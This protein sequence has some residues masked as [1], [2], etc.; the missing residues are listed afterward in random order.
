MSGIIGL[1]LGDFGLFAAFVIIGPRR[2]VLIM[3]LSPI[4][5]AVCAYLML[6]EILSQL[7]IIGIIITLTGVILV[8]LE[9]EE[10]SGE[11]IIS[12]KL[13]TW[14]V[15]LALIGAIGQGTGV[16]F[17]KKGI[18]L[19][20]T[21]IINPLSAT[22]IRMI[23]GALFVWICVIVTRRLPEIRKAIKNKKGLKYTIL[24]A[25]VGPFLG[26]TFS[27]T[28]V[29]FTQVGIA[30]TLMSLMPVMIIPVIWILY[31]QKT[32]ILGILGASIAVVG[33]AILFLI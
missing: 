25:F 7:A 4:F 21:Q 19:D 2:S 9:K 18:L 29:T 17:A 32:S 8:I 33:V 20:S 30:Q 5:A 27:M 16:V 6:G 23:L 10:R 15:F 31:K 12:K 26:V 28:A 13:K 14:G 11:D 22:L 24:G 3:T 1:G